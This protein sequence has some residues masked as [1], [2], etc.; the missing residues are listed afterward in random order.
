MTYAAEQRRWDMGR[1]SSRRVRG[2]L[3]RS[4]QD[5]VIFGIC[6]GL[7]DYLGISSFWIR[8]I[9]LIV[10]FTVFPVLIIVYVVA[11]I[12]M[13]K[14][15]HEPPPLGS[16]LD[17]SWSEPHSTPDLQVLERDLDTV[18][19]KVRILEDYV[20]SKEFVLKRKFENL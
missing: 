7:A 10:Q 6:G 15:A 16:T 19:K 2:R 4:S 8:A 11:H 14:N 9:A 20:T 1:C 5:K 13:P 17:H 12:I 18:E 3:R